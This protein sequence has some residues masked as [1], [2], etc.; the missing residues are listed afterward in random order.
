VPG[1]LDDLVLVPLGIFVANRLISSEVLAECRAGAREV[2]A[3]GK[4]VS[5]AA[6]AVIIVIWALLAAL[7]TLWVFEAIAVRSGQEG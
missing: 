4:P 5:R 1:Y 2:A 7:C 6:A 3:N